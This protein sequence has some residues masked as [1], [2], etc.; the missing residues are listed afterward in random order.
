M[1]NGFGG[2][3]AYKKNDEGLRRNR[4]LRKTMNGFDETEAYEN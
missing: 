4:S 2:T 1:K 3:E